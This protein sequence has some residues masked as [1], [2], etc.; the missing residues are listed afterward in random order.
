M[1]PTNVWSAVRCSSAAH[2][3]RSP[4][5]ERAKAR[6]FL[7]QFAREGG[8]AALAACHL[9]ASDPTRVTLRRG[10]SSLREE[11]LACLGGAT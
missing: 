4:S 10:G 5:G 6:A 2:A 3:G 9:V 8:P 11:P 1:C 7:R